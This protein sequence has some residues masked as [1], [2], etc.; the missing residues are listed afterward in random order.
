MP[1]AAQETLDTHQ[2][3]VDM[4]ISVRKSILCSLSSNPSLDDASSLVV[5][6]LFNF[7]LGKKRNRCH[8]EPPV[9]LLLAQ[10]ALWDLSAVENLNY[11]WSSETPFSALP[12]LRDRLR[13]A[14]DELGED[15]CMAC[16]SSC[17]VVVLALH[18]KSSLHMLLFPSQMLSWWQPQGMSLACKASSSVM[19]HDQLVHEWNTRAWTAISHWGKKS[20][21]SRNIITLR[22]CECCTLKCAAM[23]FPRLLAQIGQTWSSSVIN[24]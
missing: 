18:S 3:M 9:T 8:F 16:C 19:N 11:L 4:S 5:A 2:R 1:R 21:S 10:P 7:N 12:S 6:P 24:R 17:S 14:A 22:R 20:L 13:D 15:L 23:S